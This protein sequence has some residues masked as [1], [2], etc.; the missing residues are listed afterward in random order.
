MFNQIVDSDSI[1][2][3]I[4]Q[5]YEWFRGLTYVEANLGFPMREG[6]RNPTTITTFRMHGRA[7][8][9]VSFRRGP[10][11]TLGWPSTD[12]VLTTVSLLVNF[13]AR[14]K[15]LPTCR[16]AKLRNTPVGG[17]KTAL[18]CIQAVARQSACAEGGKAMAVLWQSS[19][20]GPAK[21][22]FIHVGVPHI[23]KGLGL[24]APYIPIQPVTSAI[25]RIPIS[26]SVVR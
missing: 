25:F 16:I 13:S 2:F 5:S 19:N 7:M 17:I 4:N 12:M 24:S 26:E 1:K 8:T 9:C 6:S 10:P 11:E 18:W 14:S 15:W 23:R 22:W 20:L 21:T 3:G